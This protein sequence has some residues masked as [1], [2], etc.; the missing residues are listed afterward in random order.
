MLSEIFFSLDQSKIL[1]SGNGSSAIYNLLS[2]KLFNLKYSNALLL[3]KELTFFLLRCLF[4]FMALQY[5]RFQNDL[6][7]INFTLVYQYFNAPSTF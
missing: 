7:T 3:G 4:F 6:L 1:S 2:V 5:T